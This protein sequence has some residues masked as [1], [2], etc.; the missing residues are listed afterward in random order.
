MEFEAHQRKKI[1]AL[2]LSFDEFPSYPWSSYFID[3]YTTTVRGVAGGCG[4]RT[5]CSALV[6][7]LALIF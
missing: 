2:C 5:V 6:S 1:Q 4:E 3:K 7:S